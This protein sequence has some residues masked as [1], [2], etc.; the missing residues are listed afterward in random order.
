MH[1]NN[2]AP[3]LSNTLSLHDLCIHHVRPVS[4]Q[5]L[6]EVNARGRMSDIKV[7]VAIRFCLNDYEEWQGHQ[8]PLARSPRSLWAITPY[9]E[10]RTDGSPIKLRLYFLSK[11]SPRG[12]DW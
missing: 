5:S 4:A 11:S 3:D 6:A 1:S 7:E 2:H 8:S 12:M 10:E 9:L